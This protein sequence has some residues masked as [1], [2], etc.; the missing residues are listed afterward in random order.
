LQLIKT[1]NEI[2]L[3]AAKGLRQLAD[4]YD[5]DQLLN[6]FECQEAALKDSVS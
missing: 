5:Y 1:V 2:D 4:Q 3:Q 6:L